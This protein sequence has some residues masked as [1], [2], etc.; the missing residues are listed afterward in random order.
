MNLPSFLSRD[1]LRYE[2]VLPL[3]VYLLR[4]LYLLMAGFVGTDAWSAIVSHQGPWE[5]M[6][7]MAFCVWASYATL[8]V[9]GL[10][11]PLRMLPIVVFMIGYK[12]LWVL[13]VAYPL[14]RAGTLAGSAAEPLA[15]IFM[16]A[17]AMILVVPWGYFV[18]RYVLPAEKA[19]RAPA[20]MA[21]KEVTA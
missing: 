2:G 4:L 6:R 10:L 21:S 7:A 17:P 5:P 19:A 8:A 16:F 1:P 11:H 12:T 13:I 9:F 20:N 18:R 15:D 3:Q 14:W